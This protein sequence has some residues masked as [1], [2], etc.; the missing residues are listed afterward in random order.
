MMNLWS[1][2]IGKKKEINKELLDN[3]REP[4][5]KRY[6][7][8]QELLSSNNNVLELMADMEEK[9]SGEYLFD[10]HYINQKITEIAEGVKKTVYKL[11]EISGNKYYVLHERFFEIISKIEKFLTKHWEIPAS[12]NTLSLEEIT[13]EMVDRLGGKNANLGEVRNRLRIPTPDGF[14]ISAFAFKSFME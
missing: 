9:L 8:F 11:N 1:K 4:L 10:R 6:Q 5:K 2:F 14:A 12:P 7:S 3:K 13:K